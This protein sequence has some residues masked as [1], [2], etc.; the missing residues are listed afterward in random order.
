MTSWLQDFCLVQASC[1]LLEGQ[2]HLSGVR[3]GERRREGK[4]DAVLARRFWCPAGVV[5]AATDADGGDDGNGGGD[6]GDDD[7]NG[8]D[9]GEGGSSYDDGWDGDDDDAKVSRWKA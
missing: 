5:A 2:Q 7:D 3:L 6:D 8:S 9:Y 4:E 1:T